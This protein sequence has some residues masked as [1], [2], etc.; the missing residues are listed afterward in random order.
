MQIQYMSLT[1]LHTSVHPVS[2]QEIAYVHN[3]LSIPPFI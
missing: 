2:E 3:E 1:E